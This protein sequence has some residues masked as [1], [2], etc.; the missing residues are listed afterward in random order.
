MHHSYFIMIDNQLKEYSKLSPTIEA[1]F[2]LNLESELKRIAYSKQE[3]PMVLIV[4]QGD[5]ETLY[6]IE[7]YIRR[8]LPVLIVAV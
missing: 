3:I 6:T 8:K 1:E 4:L 7:E 5:L 2:R